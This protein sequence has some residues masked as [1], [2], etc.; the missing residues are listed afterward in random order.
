MGTWGSH[1]SENGDVNLLVVTCYTRET[2]IG[3]KSKKRT[4]IE[5]TQDIDRSLR[6]P[7]LSCFVKVIAET[8]NGRETLDIYFWC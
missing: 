5:A 2:N 3:A 7:M 8:W 1:D 4:W 6:R